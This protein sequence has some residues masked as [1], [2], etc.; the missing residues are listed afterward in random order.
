M[1]A[2]TIRIDLRDEQR[3]YDCGY[4]GE[5]NHR[6]LSIAPPANLS[7]AAY[8]MLAFGLNSGVFRPPI[9]YEGPPVVASL[10]PPV[11]SQ[12]EVN[13][14]LEAYNA[15]G[16]ILG[17]GRMVIL[18]FKAAVRGEVWRVAAAPCRF[19]FNE[20]SWTE[21]SPGEYRI[22]IP[23]ETHS[24]GPLAYATAANVENADGDQENAVFGIRRTPRGDIVLTSGV[25]ASGEIFINKGDN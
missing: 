23:L 25:L 11:T 24:Q 7:R 17:K 19:A 4:I 1:K 13:M 3:R 8:Y 9:Q 12:S 10:A 20:G 18:W 6:A 5:I 2:Q 14:T 16:T 22:T 21:V 15:D